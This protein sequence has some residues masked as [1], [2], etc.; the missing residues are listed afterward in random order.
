MIVY[1]YDEHNEFAGESVTML[2]PEETKKQGREVW[3][4]PPNATTVKPPVEKEDFARVWNGSAWEYVEDHRKETGWVNGESVTIKDLG[5]LPAG[6]SE[7]PPPPTQEELNVQR[8]MEILSELDRI[9]SKAIRPARAVSLAQ[10]AGETPDEADVAKLA[11]LEAQ[12]KELRE[13]LAGLNE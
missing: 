11:E 13:E 2:D 3:L 6:W 4:M 5:P 8:R 12:A 1:L 10:A 9:D 7:T